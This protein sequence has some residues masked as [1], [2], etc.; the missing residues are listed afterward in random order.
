[1]PSQADAFAS[2]AGEIQY[3][4]WQRRNNGVTPRSLIASD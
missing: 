4:P 2:L 3:A 1:M